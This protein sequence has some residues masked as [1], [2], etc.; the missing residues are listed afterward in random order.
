MLALPAGPRT[1]SLVGR[2]GRHGD[3]LMFPHAQTFKMVTQPFSSPSPLSASLSLFL[4]PT[5]RPS[6]SATLEGKK[7]MNHIKIYVYYAKGN[8]ALTCSR[9]HIIHLWNHLSVPLAERVLSD[10]LH[11]CNI[12]ENP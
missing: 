8:I 11:Y 7:S 12:T 9:T 1:R 5:L 4:Y 3:E 10:L 2:R 6:A